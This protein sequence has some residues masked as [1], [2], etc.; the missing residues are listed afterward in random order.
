LKPC[1]TLTNMAKADLLEIGHYTQEKWGR[2]QRD[3]YLTMLDVYFHKLAANPLS[4]KNSGDIRDGYRKL[5][6]G[7]HVIFYRQTIHKK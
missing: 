6:A 2:E 7:R 3:K 4:G 1:F 5:N